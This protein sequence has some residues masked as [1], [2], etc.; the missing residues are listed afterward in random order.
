MTLEIKLVTNET[1]LIWHWH[2]HRKGDEHPTNALDGVWSSLPLLAAAAGRG[3][4]PL[5]N[6]STFLTI[7]YWRIINNQLHNTRTAS[8]W[9]LRKANSDDIC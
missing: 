4:L 3:R 9:K 8:G 6:I 5:R 7:S 2:G 1:E